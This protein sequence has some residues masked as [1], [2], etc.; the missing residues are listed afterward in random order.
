MKMLGV[1][2]GFVDYLNSGNHN[3]H[4][5]KS[6]HHL[7]KANGRYL[8]RARGKVETWLARIFGE[9][10]VSGALADETRWT[11]YYDS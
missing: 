7:R 6:W 9:W 10:E 2:R 11:G 3:V 5:A 1:D 8:G 4:S